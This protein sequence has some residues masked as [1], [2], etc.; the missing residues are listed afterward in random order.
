MSRKKGTGKRFM[1]LQ[2]GIWSP[3]CGGWLRVVNHEANLSTQDLVKLAVQ[4]DEL[5]YDF[6]Y[7]PEH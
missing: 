2:F 3:V 5:G 6:Y 1:E 7:I 4:A